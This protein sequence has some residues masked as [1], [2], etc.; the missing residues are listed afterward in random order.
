MSWKS[1]A[2][3]SSFLITGQAVPGG[4][5]IEGLERAGVLLAVSV[6]LIRRRKYHVNYLHAVAIQAIHNSVLYAVPMW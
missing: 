1:C 5:G 2:C 6:F 4:I 3:L